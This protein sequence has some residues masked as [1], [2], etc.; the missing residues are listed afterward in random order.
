MNEKQYIQS[1]NQENYT[2]R[3]GSSSLKSE[4]PTPNKTVVGGG[5]EH[6]APHNFF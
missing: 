2:H 1:I 4:G 3:G 6:R 5:G